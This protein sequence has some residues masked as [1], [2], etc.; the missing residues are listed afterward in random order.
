MTPSQSTLSIH[1]LNPLSHTSSRNNT[2]PSRT[3]LVN[4]PGQLPFEL[5]E[6]EGNAEMSEMLKYR[7][8][9]IVHFVTLRCTET[10]ISGLFCALIVSTS[11][12]S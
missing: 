12:R 5:A 11:S 7:P 4:P 1:P 6:E 8:P 10:T 3:L 9:E 2:P